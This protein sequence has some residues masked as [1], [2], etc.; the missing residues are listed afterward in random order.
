MKVYKK[1]LSAYYSYGKNKAKFRKKERI[2]MQE[3]AMKYL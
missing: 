3:N 2:S 1:A